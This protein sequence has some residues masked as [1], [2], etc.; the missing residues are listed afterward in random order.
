MAG[1]AHQRATLHD[2][3][4]QPRDFTSPDFGPRVRI[5]DIT[6]AR[7]HPP[8]A[9]LSAALHAGRKDGAPV[10]RTAAAA[11]LTL[12]PNDAEL[13]SPL[14]FHARSRLEIAK[15]FKDIMQA[16]E[17]PR[18]ADY[19]VGWKE[20]VRELESVGEA[21]GEL[22]ARATV[23]LQQ[24][25]QRGFRISASARTR[26]QASTDTAELDRWLTRVLTIQRLPDLF[27]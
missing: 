2:P 23:L 22:M 19:A 17:I 13:Y 16:H 21:R 27:T 25:R 14:V 1:V 8:R 4:R 11:L 10:M 3:P 5:T 12:P 7:E 9:I 6:L 15:L 26:I 24:L 18:D 20:Y